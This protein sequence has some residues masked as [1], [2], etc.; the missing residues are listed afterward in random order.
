MS[1]SPTVVNGSGSGSAELMIVGEGPGTHEIAQGLPFVGPS[2]SVLNELL[3]ACGTSR[4][5]VYITNVVKVK[6]PKGG[7]NYQKI[8]SLEEYNMSI[9]DFLPILWNE[10]EVIRPNCI[11]ALGGIALKY[12]TGY[13]K[14]TDYRG[15][16]LSSLKY[17][18]KVVGTIHPASLFERGRKQE[19]MFASPWR[20]KV[21]MQ[22]DFKRALEQSKFKEFRPPRR[23][24]NVARNH[25]QVYD[26]FK[27]YEGYTDLTIDVETTN[28]I[29]LCIGFAFVPYE[30]LSVPLVREL[31]TQDEEGMTVGDLVANW[32]LI[33]QKLRDPKIK[34]N[35]QNVKFDADRLEELGFAVEPITNDTMLDFHNLYPELPKKL[36]VISS[37]YTEEPYYK[38][39][40]KDFN[41]KKDDIKKLFLYNGRDSAVECECKQK[42]QG[43]IKELGL[44]EIQSKTIELFN[45]YR[46]MEHNGVLQDLNQKRVLLRKYLGNWRDNGK[47]IEKVTSHE[48]NVNSP[49]Q[50][51]RLL[52]DEL[53]C[54]FRYHLDKTGQHKIPSTDEET[55]KSLISLV[56]KPHQKEV[57]QL[58]LK[59]R[60]IWKTIG[61]YLEARCDYD[62]RIR[63]E[64][65]LTGTDTFRTS[66]SKLDSPNRVGVWGLPLQTLTKHEEVGQDLRS[67][68]VPDE[69]YC[70]IEADGSQAEARVVA[71]LARDE[72]ALSAFAA[73][74]D[75]HALTASWCFGIP[76]S[77]INKE[78]RELGK[79][80]RHAGERG[81]TYLRLA[82]MAQISNWKAQQILSKFHEESPNIINVYFAEVIE[83]LEANARILRTPHGRYRQFFD[84]WDDD[85]WKQAYSFI[86]QATVS[87]HVKFA[88]LRIRKRADYVKFI[89]ESHDSF[90]AQ[91]PIPKLHEFVLIT[92]E[93]ME[94]PIDFSKCSLPR[95][96]LVIPCEI[97][98]G[99][100]NYQLMEK[101]VVDREAV[102]RN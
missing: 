57:M 55:L 11:L 42:M 35:G 10:I 7:T 66:T 89:S 24:I 81:M 98:V 75:I 34:K 69:G 92:K 43:D 60:K 87:D 32:K 9:D 67:M 53:K 41:Y 1:L 100:K 15:S 18:I 21:I 79:R 31:T 17:G 62:G 19:G 95:G 6:F 70:F 93:E 68:F 47:E 59:G 16:I 51:A 63:T 84:R 97:K 96:M 65:H 8:K 86:P 27:R 76:P 50:V 91:V 14:I 61:T 3:R 28:T 26:F 82:Q 88:M 56:K 5:E 33:D 64:E 38:D 85:L 46:E 13:D 23:I 20:Q 30:S 77:A 36:Q 99:Y 54:P 83:A 102:G 72:R 12:L 58:V 94:T 4:D 22:F 45:L 49:K 101:Y 80:V 39:E 29:A 2:G 78:Q 90:W 48:V 37:I 40:G 25:Q 71:L 73:G 44:E 74:R 52:Y